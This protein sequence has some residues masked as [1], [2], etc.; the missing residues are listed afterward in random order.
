MMLKKTP[1]YPLLFATYPVLAL[2]AHNIHEIVLGD[3]WR[4]LV[5]SLLLAGVVLA[6]AR[7]LL[8][9]WHRAA[10]VTVLVLLLFFSYGQVYSVLKNIQVGG[11]LPFRHRSLGLVW[12][13]LLFIGI[14]WAWRWLKDPAAWTGWL[15]L[16]S[17]LLLI[18]PL[19]VIG[20]DRLNRVTAARRS[21]ES[22]GLS[23]P[24]SA[25]GP[26]VYYIILD[27]YGRHDLLKKK[28]GY[29]NGDF[30][31]GLRQRGFY[32]ADC[33]QSN[34]GFTELSLASS[35]NYDYLDS[36]P[37]DFA[38]ED[39]FDQLIQHGR[40][41]TFFEAQGYR[42]VAFATGFA[43]TEWKDANFFFAYDTPAGSLNDFETLLAQTT[44][45]RIP[46][47]VT[48]LKS[49]INIAN[50]RRA[51][52]LSALDHLKAVPDL[53]GS[54]LVFAH[55]VAPHKPYFFGPH[56]EPI[57]LDE[58]TATI[59]QRR[60]A[61]ADQ[62]R[63]ISQAILGVVD[64]IQSQSKTPPIIVI[65]GDHGPDDDL[66][67]PQER[68]QN[69]NAYFLPGIDASKV[70]YPTI[71]PVNTFRVILNT[72]FGQNLPLLKDRSLYFRFE[73]RAKPELVPNTCISQP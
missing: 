70:L 44:L 3:I 49:A 52:T 66:V 23:V 39:S 45:L 19:V 69:L 26:D 5:V 9:D 57:H 72:Y 10:L 6:L 62:A 14:I 27:G 15:N 20:Q 24:V 11:S 67:T 36:L 63:Y 35:L 42:T 38:N 32:V 17:A 8:G 4:S 2:A 46:L 56:G 65:Q 7:L 34:Y 51:R 40:V 59:E 61:Y 64:S 73:D 22:A 43:W 1:F 13:G 68:M 55:I 58:E 71:T 12:G 41:R 47:D 31:E 29:D 37:S 53:K 25:A 21:A 33:A 60:Q 50:T 54:K 16:L 48:Q 30:I 28:F 18:Y